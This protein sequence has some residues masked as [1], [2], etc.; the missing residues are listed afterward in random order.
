[1]TNSQN[2]NQDNFFEGGYN[3]CEILNRV[4][5]L[6]GLDLKKLSE[7][8]DIP[9]HYLTALANGEFEKLP[10]APYVRGYLAKIA[11]A[12]RVDENL[13]LKTYKQ[14]VSF[15]SLRASGPE[16]K[17]PANRFT[18]RASRRK[19]I[20]LAITLAAILVIV[21]IVWRADDFLGKPR[22]EIISPAAD[23]LIVNSPSIKLSGRVNGNDKLT[24]YGEEI[25]AAKD[26]SF[27]KEF[28]LQP[29]LNRI[30]FKVKRFLGGE[31]TIVRQVIYQP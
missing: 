8:T 13:L 27:E 15:R 10:A 7:L 6:R 21:F 28:F 3:L 26:G 23:N 14:E 20:L 9:V 1:M 25:L 5:E 19:R 22:I 17:L 4:T 29:G 31:T 16:D 24:I 18:F 30:E 2:K 11:E 12:L